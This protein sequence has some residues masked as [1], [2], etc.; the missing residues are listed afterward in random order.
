MK[1]PKEIRIED[2]DYPLPDARIAR[3]PARN[4]D[5][6]LLLHYHKGQIKKRRFKE[7]PSLLHEDDLLVFNETK[8]IQARLEFFKTTGARIEL[9]LLGPEQADMQ[10]AFSSKGA[11]LWKCLI[12]NAKKW[13]SGTLEMNQQHTVLKAEKLYQENDYYLIRFS[14][15]DESSF[16]EMLDL[17]GKTPL[18]PYLKRDAEQADKVRYQTVYAR[19]E[20][21]VAA[22]TAGLHFSADVFR[23]LRLK[24]IV[25]E[26]VTLHVGAGTFKPVS[27]PTVGGHQMHTEQIII[28]RKTLKSLRQQ[29][30]KRLIAVG[31]TTVR[32]LESLFWFA[33]YI[34]AGKPTFS[35]NQWVPYEMET[36]VAMTRTEVLDTIIQY[37]D[38]NGLDEMAAETQIIIAPGYQFRLV[39]AMFTNFHQ[40]KSTL[41]LLVSAYLGDDWRKVYDF[42]LARDYRFL[43]YGDSCFFEK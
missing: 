19:H 11:V 39:D 27:E 43:S 26:R 36:V 42:A 31:T 13:K 8:V 24:N 21:S 40:P 14:W 17:F 9:F 41:L 28:S 30:H 3:Y 10:L 12:G 20:G 4:R 25:T 1:N 22:P 37:L 33:Q 34:D 35:L 29:S 6:S 23:Q 2:Y 18:P 15:N 5:A 7:T 38:E 32:T 16:A